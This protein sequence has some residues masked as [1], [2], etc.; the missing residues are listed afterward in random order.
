[1][2]LSWGTCQSYWHIDRPLHLALDRPGCPG[3]GLSMICIVLLFLSLPNPLGAVGPSTFNTTGPWPSCFQCSVNPITSMPRD[4][5]LTY[6][7]L[8]GFRVFRG[9]N[10]N[11]LFP[12][13]DV[14]FQGEPFTDSLHA[15]IEG[16][17]IGSQHW[18]RD[19]YGDAELASRFP[20]AS[21]R[22]SSPPSRQQSKGTGACADQGHYN[23]M[24]RAAEGALA[25]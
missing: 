16:N 19:C 6:L 15:V 1:M 24:L 8:C 12:T 7:A 25:G 22:G 18:I 3:D 4:L 20:R 17:T 14:Y 11:H 10:P 21:S 13:F 23:T 9:R 2:R 5:L